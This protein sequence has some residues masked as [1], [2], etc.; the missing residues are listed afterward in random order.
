MNRIK[1]CVNP[2]TKEEKC[3]V[4]EIKAGQTN[5]KIVAIYAELKG[6]PKVKWKESIKTVLGLKLAQKAGLDV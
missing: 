5:E 3:R 2:K 4:A 1:L 6:N